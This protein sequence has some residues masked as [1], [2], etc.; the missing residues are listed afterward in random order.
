MCYQ[1]SQVSVNLKNAALTLHFSH[2]KLYTTM[3]NFKEK[4]TVDQQQVT[5]YNQNL[6]S[7]DKNA[8]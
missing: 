8:S 1:T 7:S 4:S 2:C 6:K 5:L 3:T